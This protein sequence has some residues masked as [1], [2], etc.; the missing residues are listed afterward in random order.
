MILKFY[1][2]DKDKSRKSFILFHG[3]NTGLK[4]EEIQKIKINLKKNNKL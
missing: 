4:F 3:N 2:L 1:E